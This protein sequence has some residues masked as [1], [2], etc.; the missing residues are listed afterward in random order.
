MSHHIQAYINGEWV[1]G[2]GGSAEYRSAY[3]SSVL[4]RF[5]VCQPSDVEMA[6]RSA[7]RAQASWAATP[8]LDKV[9]L[10]YK[11][12]ELC[13]EANE[14]IA[15]SISAEMGKTIRESRE[16]MLQYGWGHFRRAAED[17]LRFRGMTLPNSETRTNTKRMFVQQYPLGVVGVISPFNF[18]VDIPA[19]A[20]TYAL[21]AGNT[22]VWKPSEYC[23]GSTQ[24]VSSTS[25]RATAMPVRPW[26]RV[27]RCVACSSPGALGSV[28][29]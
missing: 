11:A 12:Y 4:G 28:A 3:D 15:Q 8:L 27:R 17:M 5:T 16:E 18:P 13:K 6:I 25:C 19:I 21:I 7:R 23:P 1:D 29:R 10:M 20:I 24:R 2:A 9:D 26:S 14:E 22:V